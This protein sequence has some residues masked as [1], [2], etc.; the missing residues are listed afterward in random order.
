MASPGAGNIDHMGWGAVF[1]LNSIPLSLLMGLLFGFLAG[2]GIGGGSLL[3]LWLTLIVGIDHNIARAINLMFF[4]AA[5]GSVCSYRL[6]AK[7]LP[8]KPIVPAIIAGCAAAALFSWLGKG[9]DTELLR[10]IF[11]VLFLIT[12]VRELFYRER[13]AR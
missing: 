3:M 7:D 4:I 5:A 9:M 13:K 6:K 1:M 12:G 10:K 11:G 2:L 8:I